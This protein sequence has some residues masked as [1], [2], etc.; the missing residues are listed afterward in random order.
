MESESEEEN[1]EEEEKGE[2]KEGTSAAA[3]EEGLGADNRR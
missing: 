3:D 2:E 1:G